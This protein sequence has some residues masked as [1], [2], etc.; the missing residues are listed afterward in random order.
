MNTKERAESFAR[1]V[2]L[3]LKGKIVSQGFTALK[4]AE[5]IGRSP[6]A[7]NRWLNGKSEIPLTVLCEACEVIDIE[8]RS[9]IESAYDRMA[10]A[11]GERSG[12]TYDAESVRSALADTEPE[13][14]RATV[15][16]LQPRVSDV[17]VPIAA[18]D[19]DLEDRKSV[20]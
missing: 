3:E 6:A 19:A 9:I 16:R 2:G 8:P 13:A 20:V 18:S 15:H 10:V 4:V 14:P 5:T 17:S 7:F 11:L 1:Y 12:E